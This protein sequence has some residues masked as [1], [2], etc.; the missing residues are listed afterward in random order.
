MSNFVKLWIFSLCLM[1]CHTESDSYSGNMGKL[2]AT[3]GALQIEEALDTNENA[4]DQAE[5]G[6]SSE[7]KIIKTGNMSFEVEALEKSKARVD[8]LLHLSGGYYQH[9]NFHSY[10]NKNAYALKLRIPNESYDPFIQQLEQGVGRLESKQITAS[11]VSE[12]YVDLT[13]R[14]NNNMAYLEQY[15]Q[16]LSKA[17]TVEEILEVQE[18]IRKIEEEIESKKGRLRY[19]DHRI[20]YSTL[21]LELFQKVEQLK[22]EGPSIRKKFVKAFKNGA[23]VFLSFLIGLVHLWPFLILIAVLIGARKAIW[24]RMKG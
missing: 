18:K 13:V 11:D 4:S 16:I 21:Q 9:E 22:S 23:D 19:L 2:E 6:V 3:E 1:A 24:K 8:S 14:L 10:Y 7:L 20:K 17:K 5:S 15:K 12:E